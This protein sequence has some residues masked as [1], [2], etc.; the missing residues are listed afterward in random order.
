M[1]IYS[2]RSSLFDNFCILRLTT[3][4]NPIYENCDY[5]FSAMAVHVASKKNAFR[6][7]LFISS[8]NFDWLDSCLCM[9]FP[10]IEPDA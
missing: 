8:T 6:N 5:F 10:V 3:N 7:G 1:N 9:G 2:Q 4:L